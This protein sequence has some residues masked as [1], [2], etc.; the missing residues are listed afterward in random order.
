MARQAGISAPTTNY[1]KMRHPLGSLGEFNSIIKLKGE[2]IFSKI[3]KRI[4]LFYRTNNKLNNYLHDRKIQKKF[5][6]VL[7]DIIE[8]LGEL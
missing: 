4:K 3:Y 5:L 8:E 7:K 2:K 1:K 6:K